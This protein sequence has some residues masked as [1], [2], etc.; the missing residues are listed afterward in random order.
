MILNFDPHPPD[1]S[2]TSKKWI[3]D[4]P[5]WMSCL[6]LSEVSLAAIS[7]V[8]SVLLFLSSIMG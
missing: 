2:M 4:T 8:C 1:S 7:F 6:R 3:S 5:A